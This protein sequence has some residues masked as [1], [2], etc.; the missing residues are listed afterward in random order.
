MFRCTSGG[1]Q[2]KH[3][4]TISRVKLIF[5][6]FSELQLSS[7]QWSRTHFHVYS[8]LIMLRLKKIYVDDLLF[9]FLFT[10]CHSHQVHF[11][12]D[13]LFKQG[14]TNTF[15]SIFTIKKRDAGRF[16]S[17][18]NYYYIKKRSCL[19]ETC[20]SVQDTGV[21]KRLSQNRPPFLYSDLI[22]YAVDSVTCLRNLSW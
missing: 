21:Q 8:C 14:I 1:Q 19:Q 17:D 16:F 4:N 20:Q 12:D 7:Q 3:K 18:Y 5:I 9:L 6:I 2:L 10:F 11:E 15:S 13:F 22:K